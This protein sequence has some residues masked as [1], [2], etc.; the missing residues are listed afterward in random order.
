MSAAATTA[1]NS[2]PSQYLCVVEQSS[3]LHYD[4]QAHIWRPQAFRPGERYIL[5]KL[6]EDDRDPRNK[7]SSM[8]RDPKVTWAFFRLGDDFPRERCVEFDCRPSA[9]FDPDSL[10]FEIRNYGSYIDQG[11]WQRLRREDPK[12]H[13]PV[14]PD[15]PD[16]LFIEI[17]G[18]GPDT[19]TAS[20]AIPQS[21]GAQ[22]EITKN[23]TDVCARRC[24]SPGGITAP[25]DVGYV[26]RLPPSTDA[27][28]R[29]C[30]EEIGRTGQ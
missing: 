30:G 3:G 10:R 28:L 1:A 24:L 5:R 11:L 8:Y 7:W 19:G 23:A 16:D 29:A 27:C 20:P 6:T 9:T 14:D 22:P 15:R 13:L 18:C 4:D 21:M 26:S 12:A 25:P 2:K 17:G